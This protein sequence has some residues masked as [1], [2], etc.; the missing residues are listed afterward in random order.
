MSF[1]IRMI[2]IVLP[3]VLGFAGCQEP[4]P[5]EKHEVPI[6]PP[7]E[8]RQWHPSEQP[9]QAP[10]AAGETRAATAP[11]SQTAT[12]TPPALAQAG[13]AGANAPPN[14]IG[15]KPTHPSTGDMAMPA[16]DTPATPTPAPVPTA[17]PAPQPTPS[18]T[19]TPAPTAAAPPAAAEKP[20]SPPPPPA[21]APQAPAPVAPIAVDRP[22]LLTDLVTARPSTRAATTPAQPAAPAG[23]AATAPSPLASAANPLSLEADAGSAAPVVATPPPAPQE[24]AAVPEAAPKQPPTPP[25]AVSPRPAPARPSKARIGDTEIV[26]ASG[27]QVNDRYITTAQILRAAANPLAE[28]PKNLTEPA[29]R[30]QAQK[31]IEDEI[32]AQIDTALVLPE[33]RKALSDDQKKQIDKE[34]DDTVRSMVAEAG[35]SRKKLEDVQA[36]RGTTLEEVLSDQREKLTVQLY[37][38]M[39]FQ[40][41]T[42]VGRNALYDYYRKNKLTQFTVDTKV[43]MQ[44]IAAPFSQYVK[45]A[46]PTD[47]ELKAAKEEARKAI[48]E[49]DL[50]L[51]KGEDMGEVAKRL[52][53]GPNAASGGLWPLMTR[54]SFRQAKVEDVAFSMRQG[55]VSDI[56]ETDGGFY[57][58][59]A[60]LVMPGKTLSFEEAQDTI[61][62]TLSRE[63]SRRL[64]LE[65]NQKLRDGAT[66]TLS[67]RLIP[68]AIEKAVQHYWLPA[69]PE[70]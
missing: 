16:Q 29:F 31:I 38:Q 28:L 33:A 55:Q 50:A 66:I 14:S 20:V 10:L 65:Y 12:Q 67:D 17:P 36:E 18:P 30:D 2:L 46:Q 58:V 40:N 19:A 26:G 35:G 68:L 34:L 62:K 37:F 15:N 23:D 59:K 45:V 69:H 21:A 47:D 7:K 61:E 57:I 48:A 64:Q 6:T 43:Q 44:I 22:M 56:I 3:A 60:L 70:K 9:L 24:P 41:A 63:Q 32:H 54:G 4:M 51:A 39:R 53:K 52:S 11:A 1:A 5:W 42:S 49:A 27:V 25:V 13:P 8:Q